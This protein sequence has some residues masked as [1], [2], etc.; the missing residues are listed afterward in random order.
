MASFTSYDFSESI[1][2]AEGFAMA[3][4]DS[5]LAAWGENGDYAEWSGGFLLRLKDGRFAYVEGWC[6]TT[7][8]GCQDGVETRL[9]DAEPELTDLSLG[10]SGKPAVRDWAVNPEDLN[11][12]IRGEIKDFDHE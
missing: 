5:A 11:R 10:Y 2:Q 1:A 9:F 7:G 3:D 6:D 12:L 8:W 4:I